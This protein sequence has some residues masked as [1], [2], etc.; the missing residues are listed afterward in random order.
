[1]L[2]N[3]LTHVGSNALEECDNLL[4]VAIPDSVET[5]GEAALAQCSQLS[6]ANL[7]LGLEE[8]APKA[9]LDCPLGSILLSEKVAAIGDSVFW[10]DRLAAVNCA[11]IESPAIED[12]TTYFSADGQLIDSLCVPVES[13][14]TYETSP[15]ARYFRAVRGVVV[16]R[17]LFTECRWTP[18][19][20]LRSFLYCLWRIWIQ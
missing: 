16:L 11:A 13:V 20:A 18:Q 17:H 5:I 3:G 9:F 15:W 6:I 10:G 1:M 14:A 8:I 4:S 2:P 7:S 12:A 19:R